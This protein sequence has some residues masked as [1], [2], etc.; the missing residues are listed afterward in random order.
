MTQ[1]EDDPGRGPE[2]GSPLPVTSSP[3]TPAPSAAG[4]DPD[5][6]FTYANERTFLAWNRTALALVATGV[7]A[8]QF[9]PKLQ[10]TWGRRLLG[11]PLILLGALVAAESFRHWRANER[12]MRQGA[13][14]PRSP[15]PMV[16]AVGIFV[17]GVAAAVLAL[18]GSK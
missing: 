3:A 11:I 7:A 5:V 13:P 2:P 6:R 18:F 4:A 8:T 1:G 12:A 9:L 17:V 14:L 16:L 15:M 10:V